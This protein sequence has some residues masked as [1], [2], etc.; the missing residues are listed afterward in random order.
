MKQVLLT[1]LLTVATI[2]SFAQSDSLSIPA[3]TISET[4]NTNKPSYRTWSIGINGGGTMVG[5]L[6]GGMNDFTK[7]NV[8]A[9]FGI[10]VQKDLTH[11]LSLKADILMGS[12]SGN[13]DRLQGDGS[14]RILKYANYETKV[15]YA[16]SFN[17]VFNLLN[18][19]W[20][21][22]NNTVNLFTTL[23][24][25][26]MGYTSNGVRTADS[27]KETLKNGSTVAAL[28]FPVSV[29][30]KVKLSSMM[31]LELGYRVNLVDGDNLDMTHY[32]TNQDKF[33]YAY[34]GLQIY[35]GNKSKPVMSWNNPT[36]QLIDKTT[37]ELAAMR[38]L[39][40]ESERQNKLL[41]AKMDRLITDSDGDGV[42]DIV[43]KCPGTAVNTKVNVDGCEEVKR[44]TVASKP[45]EELKFSKTTAPEATITEEDLKVV[46]EAQR[47]LAFYSE[48]ADIDPSSHKSLDKL[49]LLMIQKGYRLKLVGYTDNIG[50]DGY[51]LFFSKARA[52][53]V[54]SY[55]VSAGISSLKIEATGFGKAQ[56]IAPNNTPEG[57][58]KNNRVEFTLLEK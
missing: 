55:L 39:L 48:R 33:S 17:V 47:N 8:G 1:L 19:N 24:L 52:E 16:G 54:K 57:R 49:A 22:A 5:S 14:K 34:M 15:N 44:N 28:Y 38:G 21:T 3:N 58:K 26:Y 45:V 53:S 13:N 50:D 18:T 51:N 27:M 30:A 40:E 32:G 20:L 12:F 7:N 6:P 4:T 56:P 2:T 35:L 31:G 46:K 25:G 36:F 43:D 9:G 42:Y 10:Y 11:L 41:Q 37:Q 29:G 23:G